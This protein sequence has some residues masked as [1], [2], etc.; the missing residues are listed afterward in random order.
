MATCEVEGFAFLV[1]D[2]ELEAEGLEAFE[3]FDAGADFLESGDEGKEAD[4]KEDDPVVDHDEDTADDG[5][6]LYLI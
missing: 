2:N 3:S 4:V 1:R 6:L 5:E